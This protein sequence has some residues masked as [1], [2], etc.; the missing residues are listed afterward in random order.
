VCDFDDVPAGVCDFDD[1][2]F[3]VWNFDIVLVGVCNS[4]DVMILMLELIA[5]SD[6]VFVR[7]LIGVEGEGRREGVGGGV[8]VHNSGFCNENESERENN[9]NETVFPLIEKQLPLKE[10]LVVKTQFTISIT[11]LDVHVKVP[12]SFVL[13]LKMQK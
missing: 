2:S 4:N 8:A 5:V 7:E 10:M 3:G 12:I 11:E 9:D 1:V 13:F 6:F